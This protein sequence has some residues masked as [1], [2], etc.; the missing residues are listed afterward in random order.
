[1]NMRFY[2]R[3]GWRHKL[4]SGTKRQSAALLAISPLSPIYIYLE[5]MILVAKTIHKQLIYISFM[6]PIYIFI[7]CKT[8][9]STLYLYWKIY[10]EKMK[11][12]WKLVFV[13]FH[14]RLNQFA[15]KMSQTKNKKGEQQRADSYDNFIKQLFK[16]CLVTSAV[17]SR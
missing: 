8:P 11:M 14:P 10:L 4:P 5:K 13:L 16:L 15:T 7:S 17:N 3:L 6:S 2:C 9:T 1:M 12:S